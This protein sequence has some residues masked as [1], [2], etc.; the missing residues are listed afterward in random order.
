M[1]LEFVHISDTISINMINVKLC[2][3]V[4]PFGLYPS[5][6][7]LVTVTTFVHSEKVREIGRK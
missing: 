6:S 2:M 1:L 5:I 4:V 7:L 3:M